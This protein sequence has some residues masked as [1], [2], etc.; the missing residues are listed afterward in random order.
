MLLGISRSHSGS[1][2]S[3]S[4]QLECI[5]CELLKHCLRAG[6]AQCNRF[7]IN[8]ARCFQKPVGMVLL[9]ALRPE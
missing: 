7:R 9:L 6:E 1:A 8:V 5:L 3:D 2:L 4:S